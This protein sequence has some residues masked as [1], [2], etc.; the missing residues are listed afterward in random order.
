[1]YSIKHSKNLARTGVIETSHGKLKTPTVFPL[2]KISD[3]GFWK[4]IEEYLPKLECL[5]VNFYEAY[6]SGSIAKVREGIHSFLNFKRPI[7]MDSGG[8]TL[9]DTDFP[10]FELYKIQKESKSDILSTLDSP[11]RMNFAWGHSSRI[12]KNI[13]NALKIMK[14]NCDKNRVFASVHARDSLELMCYLK[15]LE[16]HGNFDGYA[17]GG[18]VPIAQQ[19]MRIV[20]LIF[21]A[22]KTIAN[23]P[24]HVY[25]LGGFP[26]AI[27]LFY[28]GVDS[29]DASTFTKAGAVREYLVPGHRRVSLSK[30]IDQDE[31]PCLCPVCERHSPNELN[32]N[33]ISIHN[34]WAT[35]NEIR[36]VRHEIKNNSFEEYAKIRLSRNR[37]LLAAFEY[38]KFLIHRARGC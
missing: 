1:M 15:F 33:L 32:R 30:L 24:I 38:L 23:K 8:Y 16:R 17:I 9:K 6:L 18:L 25:G 22:R 27:L 7:F 11:L 21:A 20:R 19:P 36:R 4:K 3:R 14:E 28:S 35:M 10:I 13:K 34:L 26:T 31:L 5:M 37:L 29:V 12:H 2:L